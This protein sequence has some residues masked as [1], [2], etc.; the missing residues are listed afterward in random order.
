[1]QH[2]ILTNASYLPMYLGCGS[3][4]AMTVIERNARMGEGDADEMLVHASV[5]GGHMDTSLL[6][7]SFRSV[8][9]A[10]VRLLRSRLPS[11]QRATGRGCRCRR[12]RW[13][14]DCPWTW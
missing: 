8:L 14:V 1:M 10:D 3:E 5:L 2:Q 7:L 9:L 4:S 6:K 12:W 13:P 11:W